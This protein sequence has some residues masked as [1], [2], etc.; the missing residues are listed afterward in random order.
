MK[1]NIGK[2]PKKGNN[3]K[4]DIK[5]EQFDTYSMDHTLA[6]IILPMLLQLKATKHGVPHE[7][8]EVGGEDYNSQECFDFYREDYPEM[9]NKK[10]LEWDNVLDKMIWSFQQLAIEDYESKYHHGKM[11]FEWEKNNTKMLNPV[12]GKMETT[13]KMIDK[14]PDEHWFDYE[15]LELHNKRIQEGIDLFAKYYRNLWD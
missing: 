7:F 3:R 2:Y 8:S 10:I 5:I 15:G 6:L 14:N 9:F 1:I 12:T 4:I 11:E 13:F